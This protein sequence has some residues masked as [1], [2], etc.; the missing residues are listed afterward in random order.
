[1]ESV[2]AHEYYGQISVNLVGIPLCILCVHISLPFELFCVSCFSFQ[3]VT[4]AV[5]VI[6]LITGLDMSAF[7]SHGGWNKM[8]QRL[9]QE[10]TYCAREVP[11]I[12]PSE[13]KPAKKQAGES[14]QASGVSGKESHGQTSEDLVLLR[15]EDVPMETSREELDSTLKEEG[16]EEAEGSRMEREVEGE[17]EKAGEDKNGSLMCMP[18]RAA[19]I[20][21]ILN[22]L[23]KAIP[24]PTFAENI[25]TRRCFQRM[26]IICIHTGFF[27]LSSVCLS[28]SLPVSLLSACLS[29]C[30]SVCMSACLSVFVVVDSPLPRSL[31]HIVSNAEYY[32]PSIYLPGWHTYIL[33]L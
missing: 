13:L 16:Q 17:G 8:L 24:E 6:D 32:G 28:V 19:L 7:H 9:Q 2:R 14:S 3:L 5:R 25:R 20:K 23:K 33:T 22:F 12:L 26:Y 15:Y 11:G 1:M 29:V 10:V 4:R 31:V 27:M 18:E 30:M 21:S